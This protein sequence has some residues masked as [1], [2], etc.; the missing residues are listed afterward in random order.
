MVLIIVSIVFCL[1]L[2]D[3]A[4]V[5]FIPKILKIWPPLS[6]FDKDVLIEDTVCYRIDTNIENKLGEPVITNR[7]NY[8]DSLCLVLRHQVLPDMRVPQQDMQ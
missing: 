1:L 4:I 6:K 3:F 2:F 5:G 7:I 8:K